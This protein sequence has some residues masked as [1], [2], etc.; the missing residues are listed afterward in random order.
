MK[1]LNILWWLVYTV[2]AIFLQLFTV[3][4]DFFIPAIIVVLQEKKLLQS[5][6]IFCLFICIQEGI[7]TMPFG[8]VFLWYSLTVILFYAWRW[9]FEVESLMFILLLSL[10]LSICHYFIVS[11]LASV[12]DIY[13]D[14]NAL[15]DECVYQMFITPIIWHAMSY[16]RK[17]LRNAEQD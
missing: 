14:Y 4:V 11:V 7:G 1:V 2:F 9:F 8:N 15:R 12:Q 5:S 10:A 3:G 13:I 17:G 16:L 6:I